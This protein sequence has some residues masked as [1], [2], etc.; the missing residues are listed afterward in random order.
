[1]T[2]AR[3]A[4]DDAGERL[5][6]LGQRLRS[7]YEQQRGGDAERSRADV[8]DAVRRLSE[9]VQDAFEALGSAAKDPAVKD[10]ARRVGE[11]LTDALRT[12]ITEV[13]GELRTAFGTRGGQRGG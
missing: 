3:S 13:S 10:D 2:E 8:E 4:W 11:S 1:M 9:A 7:H 6:A 5:G 12:T